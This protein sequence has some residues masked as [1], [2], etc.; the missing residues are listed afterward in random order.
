MEPS[1]TAKPKQTG[2]LRGFLERAAFAL[3]P[4]GTGIVLDALD[5][6]T[7]GPVGI[8]LGAVVGGTAGWILGQYERFDRSVR[9]GFALCAAAYLTIPLTEP[10]PLATILFLL[11]RFFEGP[12]PSRESR[13]TDTVEP[14]TAE[15]DPVVGS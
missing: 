4:L 11:A 7:F 10:I 6:A 9:I 2:E 3:G 8:M 13:P 14:T 5:F 12:R 15:R 1:H